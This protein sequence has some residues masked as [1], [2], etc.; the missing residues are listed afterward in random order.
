MAVGQERYD[1]LVRSGL[2]QVTGV[3]PNAAE[4]AR[5][6]GRKGPYQ[7][8][9]VFLGNGARATFH[10]TRY[11]GCS[12]LLKPNPDL[13]DK[14]MT[15]GCADPG[16]NFHVQRT[17]AVETVRLDDLGPDISVDYLKI[18]VQGY[19]LEIMRHGTTKLSH[20][21]VIETEVEFVPIYWEQPLLGDIQCFLRDHGFVLH[22]LIDIAGRPFRP[23]SPP[24][25]F[26]PVSQVLWADAIFVRDFT[27]LDKYTDDGLLKAVAVL[28]LVYGSY[29]LAAL[30]L[31]E[32]DRRSQS[33]LRERYLDAL[34]KRPLSPRCLNV[35]DRP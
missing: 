14:F 9:P 24:N 13:I 22:K 34:R 29:D 23:F 10:V 5:L 25:P 21:V 7:Y 31:G 6:Q 8:L 27:R 20:A 30:L 4:C 11:P 26:L 19:E 2:A 28:D 15:I 1:S 17:E 18:D 12:S 3:E 33:R 32:F 35:L 16:G